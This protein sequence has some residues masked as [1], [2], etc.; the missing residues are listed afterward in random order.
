MKQRKVKIYYSRQF[1]KSRKSLS[2]RTIEKFAKK[3]LLFQ[4]DPFLPLLRTHKLKGQLKG[5]YSFSIDYSHRVLFKF[6]N[7]KKALFIDIG[8]HEIYQ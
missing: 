6:I 5:L 4:Q 1:N 2:H 7:K 8:T 3:K